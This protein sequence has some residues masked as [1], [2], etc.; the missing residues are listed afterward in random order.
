MKRIK[1]TDHFYLH[2]FTRSQTAARY[3][4]SNVP[5]ENAMDNIIALCQNVLEPIRTNFNAPVSISSGYRAPKLNRKIGGSSTSQHMIGEAADFSVHGKELND[6]FNWI[7]FGMKTDDGEQCIEPRPVVEFDQVIFEFGRW[8]H[9]SYKR[10]EPNRRSILRADKV[11][12]KWGRKKT[13]YST[14]DAP[15]R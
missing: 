15:I 8:I 7:A 12:T 2:E 10:N 11:T 14:V 9:V 1:L 13:V 5:T 6:V 3:G 4:I